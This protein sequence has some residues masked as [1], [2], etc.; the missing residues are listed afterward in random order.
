MREMREVEGPTA[1]G[2]VLA[3]AAVGQWVEAKVQDR[4]A[5]SVAEFC[6]RHGFSKWFLYSEWRQGRGPRFFWV[7]DRRFITR[8]AAADWRQEQEAETGPRAA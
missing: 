4:D 1:A 6:A 3:I 7:G 8:E 2:I 5:Y